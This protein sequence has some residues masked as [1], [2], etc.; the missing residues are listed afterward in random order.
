MGL[1]QHLPVVFFLIAELH[2]YTDY[3][4]MGFIGFRV[5]CIYSKVRAHI[6][7]L[8]SMLCLATF[9]ADFRFKPLLLA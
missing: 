1:S 5:V 8:I 4:N 2:S 9:Y 6:T 7:I 3:V